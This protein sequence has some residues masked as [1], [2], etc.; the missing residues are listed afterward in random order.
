MTVLTV[1]EIPRRLLA[2]LRAVYGER[3]EPVVDS[4]GEYVGISPDQPTVTADFPGE[5]AII[6]QYLANQLEERTGP[7]VAKSS[8]V[9]T[10][11]SSFSTISGQKRPISSCSAPKVVVSSKA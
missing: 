3:A 6:E 5:D 9:R 2:D 4:D 11:P 8:T 7:M 10:A 1:V